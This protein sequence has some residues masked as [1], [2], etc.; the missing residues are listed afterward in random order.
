[1]GK[2]QNGLGVS[3]VCGDKALAN[4][5]LLKHIWE[6]KNLVTGKHLSA[7]NMSNVDGTTLYQGYL[8]CNTNVR[9]YESAP[10]ALKD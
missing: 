3:A 1:M 7:E 6:F 4:Y 2:R 8:S 9:S 10:N 5:I